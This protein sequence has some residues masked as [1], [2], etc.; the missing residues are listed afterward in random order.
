MR[1][2]KP[3]LLVEDDQVDAM[4]V[5][6]ALNQ[7]SVTN[8]LEVAKNGVEALHFLR[9]GKNTKPCLILLDLNMPRMNGL[10]FISEVKKDNSLKRYPII[11]LTTSNEEQDKRD[12]YALG[13]AGYFVK[14]VDYNDVVKIFRTIN[15]YW[16]M[17]EF[18]EVAD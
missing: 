13:I 6:R 8:E 15:E 14:P 11:I 9:Q 5:R 4:T 3:I 1:S 10:E 18:P 2:K 12:C 17:S 16:T 7:L